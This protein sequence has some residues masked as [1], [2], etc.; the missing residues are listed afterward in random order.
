MAVEMVYNINENS[1]ESNFWTQTR[2]ELAAEN[3]LY[4]FKT[5]KIVNTIPIYNSHECF[6]EFRADVEVLLNG[7]P[8]ELW[9][10]ILKEPFLGHTEKS[11]AESS[12]KSFHDTVEC[13]AWTLK[14]AHHILT[15]EAMTGKDITA[16]DQIVDFGSGIGE[17]ARMI[18]DM[19]FKG[20]YLLYDLPET[21]RISTFYLS[22]YDNVKAI[23]N[24]DQIPQRKKTLFIATWSLSEV[25]YSYRNQILSYLRENTDFLIIFQKSAWFKNGQNRVTQNNQEPTHL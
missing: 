5:W 9:K 6:G 19:G 23:E 1:N 11:Y 15:Y 17:T 16:Y 18:L 12:R 24:F 2:K 22:K 3:D 20:D 14:S 7:Q 21:A 10:K 13:S 4:T 8:N 25:P